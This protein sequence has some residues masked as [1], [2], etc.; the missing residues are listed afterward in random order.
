[1]NGKSGA[2]RESE[3]RVRVVDIVNLSSSANALLKERVLA[4]R[5]SGLDNRIVCMDGP[6]VLPL[7]EAGIPV[8]TVHLPR[9][10]D[11]LKLM[12][13]MIEIAVYLRRNRVDL[14]HT[15]CSVPGAVGRIA[16]WLA[17]AARR[18]RR[19]VAL[20]SQRLRRGRVR[21][22]SISGVLTTPSGASSSWRSKRTWV[23]G[24]APR[25]HASPQ[26]RPAPR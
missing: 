17:G 26:T 8:H 23:R 22:R 12:V 18:R 24:T 4:M 1:M 25:K 15:H 9:G 20:A 16:A 10:L 5:R 6:H 21:S 13:S 14:V 2:E 19:C 11:P 3:R 7:R